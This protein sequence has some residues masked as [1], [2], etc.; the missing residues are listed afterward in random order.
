MKNLVSQKSIKAHTPAG[1]IIEDIEGGTGLKGTNRDV[2]GCQP[3]G[4]WSREPVEETIQGC[5]V[6]EAAHKALQVLEEGN[7]AGVLI[8]DQ[9]EDDW[10]LQG[11]VFQLVQQNF[12]RI[13]RVEDSG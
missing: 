5:G 3:S 6:Q 7:P 1:H 9:C 10:R 4:I 13:G 2:Y 11:C 12:R 8:G